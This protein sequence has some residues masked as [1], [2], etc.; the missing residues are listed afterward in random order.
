MRNVAILLCL[1]I[2]I[3][4]CATT[5]DY[6]FRVG[7]EIRVVIWKELDEKVVVRPDKKISLPLVGEVSC[8]N[9]TPEELSNELS[10]KYETE[11]TVIV[12][13]YHTFKDDFKEIVGIIRDAAVTYFIGERIARDR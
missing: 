11:T 2:F 1:T 10:D 6:R 7:D 3:S 9:K 4:G 8:K 12:Q 5:G 13:K